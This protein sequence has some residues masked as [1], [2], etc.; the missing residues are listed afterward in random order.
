VLFTK[1]RLTGF[2]SFVEPT[3][4]AIEPGITGIVGPNGCGKSNVVEA[5]RWVMGE[6]S[7]KQM[8]GGEMDDVIFGGTADRPA[9]NIA[10]VIVHLQNSERD[11]PAQFNDADELEIAR[12]IERGSGSTYRINGREVRA[13]DVQLLFADLTTG[14]HSTAIVSQGRVGALISAKP[15]DRRALLEEAA[16][17]TGLHS[18]RHEAE[19]RLR[20]AE[21]NLERLEDVIEAL[22]GQYQGL[23]RQS[24][25]A[26]R[27]R[28]ISEQL[29]QLEAVS[30]HLR[31][32][33]A[34]KARDE[35]RETLRKAENAVAER[36]R[37]ASELAARQADVSA[38][39]PGLRE[40]EAEASAELQRL[41]LARRELDSE[42]ERAQ[43]QLGETERQLTEIAS[44]IER[45][46][47]LGAD[48]T[49]ALE[50]ITAEKTQLDQASDGEE[51]HLTSANL[52]LEK[53]R[54]QL[55]VREG[56]QNELTEQVAMAEARRSELER[57]CADLRQ[58]VE[59]LRERAKEIGAERE[60]LAQT[61]SEDTALREA[62]RKAA[63]AEA[64]VQDARTKLD[65]AETARA[66]ADE[67]AVA[68]RAAVQQAESNQAKL[69][70]E[71]QAL[72]EL[73]E[74]DKAGLFPPLIDALVVEP[75]YETA[76]GAAL[77]D[78]LAAPLDTA[79]DI[80]WATLSPLEAPRPLPAGARPFSN[81]VKA[82][83]ALARR[84]AL[85]GVIEEPT[86]GAAFAEH[87]RPGQRIVSKDGALW[88][89]DGFTVRAG[90]PTPAAK[91]LQQR[92][93]LGE[94]RAQREEAA[95]ELEAA[96]RKH[97]EVLAA[98]EKAAETA[99]ETR[100]EM[101][102]AYAS[103]DLARGEH[104]EFSREA[105]G[106]ESRA[107]ALSDS[108]QQV[109]DDLREAEHR[110]TES[111]QALEAVQ[112]LS[113]ARERSQ[114]LRSEVA[115][116]RSAENDLRSAHE[117]I[118]RE[119]EER[120]RR[121]AAIEEEER[122]WQGRAD[123][124]RSRLHHLEERRAAAQQQR[125]SLTARPDKIK[126]QREQLFDAVE[127]AESA[128]NAKADGLAESESTLA[129]ADK[130][131]RAAESALAEARE[132]RIRCE[133]Q[134]EQGDAACRTVAE[135]ITER[136]GCQPEEVLREAR[137]D[138]AEDAPDHT[139]VEQKIERLARQRDAMG[140][141][142]L[143]AE[144]ERAELEEQITGMQSERDD[145]LLAIARLRQGIS[146][147]NREGRERLL[148]AF[149]TVNDHFQELFVRLYGGGRAHLALTDA[150]DP[151]EAGLE[152]MASPP[153]KKL[154][155]LSLLS[156]GEQALT[157]VALLFGVFL[158]NPAP[159]CVLDE[160]D[161]PLDD[162]NVDRFCSLLEEIAHS[163]Q[164]RFLC[165]THHRMTMARMDRLFGVTMGERGVSQVVS[166][167]L[168]RAEQ[169]RETA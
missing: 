7:A 149:H 22:Q 139:E 94:L 1:L 138:S 17:I 115:M 80:H 100:M 123:G 145:L 90:A 163:S 75:G 32:T 117:R 69:A 9:R 142:N 148:A 62:E 84:L 40:A 77:G 88:R 79:A 89:W 126:E 108:A 122:S 128:R 20:A 81:F 76:L 10:E 116:L 127:R 3:E 33:E 39:M 133:A 124:A 70:A 106:V 125:E 110:L 37:A 159:I 44:D 95:E 25:Q 160:V 74:I 4:V 28:N 53:S 50:R 16:G 54:T 6:S 132:E 83:E 64:G 164:T 152:I 73:L 92:N 67:E 153:G 93:R 56:E 134:T 59:R 66:E 150:D 12:R 2:K 151:L 169:L 45:E 140:P 18:R 91:R 98:A 166:V 87:L 99:R 141:V 156:G 61:V 111:E 38:T 144:L 43:E 154:Q 157:A 26:T 49:E 65:A 135:R 34:T 85:I 120:E 72:A 113:E 107:T 23:R 41:I 24:R 63:A 42:E 168:R 136:L 58:G 8:R 60:R 31:W 11:A 96:S 109:L 35:A 78:D 119:T 103:L 101:E 112:D 52:A 162:A 71:E 47:H 118:M 105:A 155:V 131:L 13:R 121:V 21:T 29:R 147:L 146:S 143:R 82:P 14:A 5:L 36:T 137:L 15:S 165:V 129:E 167:D 86:E 102:R 68:A 161:A 57:Q 51:E 114:S 158:T 19:I 104:S 30:L 97:S 27:Y 130:A 48:A 46:G 55:A